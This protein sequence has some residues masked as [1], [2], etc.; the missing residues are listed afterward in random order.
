MSKTFHITD[1]YLQE[2]AWTNEPRVK[3]YKQAVDYEN[4]LETYRAHIASLARYPIGDPIVWDKK[5]GITEEDFYLH[6]IG[7]D[8]K[9]Y[10]WFKR[11]LAPPVTEERTELIVENLDLRLDEFCLL[12][13]H[14]LGHDDIYWQYARQNEGRIVMNELPVFDVSKYFTSFRDKGF[15]VKSRNLC[16]PIRDNKFKLD[17][18]VHLLRI[19][20]SNGIS[21]TIE[22]DIS[23]L[24]EMS[25]PLFNWVKS[26]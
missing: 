2:D 9:V 26:Q 11:P 19:F 10:A 13:W 8:D 3:D 7:I 20:K 17:R 24:R 15:S 16:D 25:P 18:V 22:G 4:S 23:E 12:A 6:K 5:T 21:I 1:G 14:Q